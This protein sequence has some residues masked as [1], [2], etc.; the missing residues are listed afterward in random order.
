MHT[1]RA[2]VCSYF[3]L[4]F[5]RTLYVFI[6]YS[7][8]GYLKHALKLHASYWYKKLM[9]RKWF[10]KKKFH[11]TVAKLAC[12]EKEIQSC[13]LGTKLRDYLQIKNIKCIFE[14]YCMIIHNTNIYFLFRW[15]GWISLPDKVYIL[16]KLDNI[17][18]TYSECYVIL[19]VWHPFN[20]LST[21][22]LKERK[23]NKIYLNPLSLRYSFILNRYLPIVAYESLKF[24]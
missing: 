18:W 14:S 21:T 12:T 23:W 3:F 16:F 15:I 1:L 5:I 4:N 22:I 2:W 9:R 11:I 10:Q 17:S 6:C 7:L 24:L 19:S 13:V 20:L 8:N